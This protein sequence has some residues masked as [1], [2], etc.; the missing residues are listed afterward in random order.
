MKSLFKIVCL[1]D[2]DFLFLIQASL[3]LSRSHSEQMTT[4]VDLTGRFPATIKRRAPSG[5]HR[6]PLG[7]VRA[8][9]GTKP[10]QGSNISDSLRPFSVM[11]FSTVRAAHAPARC[12]S[13]Q[14]GPGFL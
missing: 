4:R 9:T 7:K 10:P 6:V 8:G 14:D 5:L 3:P 13:E 1:R 12:P 2:S 11:G